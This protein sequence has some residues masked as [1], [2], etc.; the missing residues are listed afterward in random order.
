ML[1]ALF[2]CAAAVQAWL[3]TRVP[4]AVLVRVQ[5]SAAPEALL[6]SGQG[7]DAGEGVGLVNINTAGA[8]EL[9][10]LPGIGPAM[11][12][13]IIDWREQNGPFASPEEIM[14]V[15][16]IGEKTYEALKGLIICEEDSQ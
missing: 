4:E 2:L 3:P 1:T 10:H 5:T 9:C 16:G 12:G 6:R 8:D 14:Q 11:A 7:E 15:S 13:R